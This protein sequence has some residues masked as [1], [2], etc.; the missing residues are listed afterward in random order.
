[1]KSQPILNIFVSKNWQKSPQYNYTEF[2][3]FMWGQ[4]LYSLKSNH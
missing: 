2:L 4:V 3:L 1:M